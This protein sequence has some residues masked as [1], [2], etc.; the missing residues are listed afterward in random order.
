MFPCS[1]NL[2][3]RT[4]PAH[5]IIVLSLV[6]SDPD[7]PYALESLDIRLTIPSSY[8]PDPWGLT[9]LNKD[10]PLGFARNLEKGVE[11]HVREIG[12]TLLGHLNWLDRN[13]ENLLGMPP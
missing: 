10:I 12:G 6:P 7:F 5:T 3:F 1:S 4:T 11:A 8:P 13:M 9:V 2:T